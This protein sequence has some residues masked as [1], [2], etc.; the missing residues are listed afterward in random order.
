MALFMS[1]GGGIVKSDDYRLLYDYYPI[2]L[3]LLLVITYYWLYVM[4]NIT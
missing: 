1:V 4:Y 2:Y 3:I